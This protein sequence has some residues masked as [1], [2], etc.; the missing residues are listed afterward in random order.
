[1]LYEFE[2]YDPD[3]FQ[4][5]LGRLTRFFGKSSPAAPDYKG[6]ADAT[7]AGNLEAARAAAAANRVN[8]VTPYGTLNYTH[9][10][11]QG[12]D[13]GWTATQS[14]APEQQQQLA[15][16][17]KLTTG[18]L[19]TAGTGLGYVNDALSTG[20]K[21]D[22]SKLSQMPIAG[23]SVQD[24]IMS[25]LQPQIARNEDTL[26]TRLQNSGVF[27]G[28]E[29]WK[30]AM[31]DQSLSENDLY[32]NAALQGIN[33]GLQARQQGI[34]EQYGAQDRPLNIVNALRTGNQVQTPTFTNVPQ[35]Q[36]T[37][38]ADMLTAASQAGQFASGNAASQN[39][40]TASNVGSAA[41]VAA[42]YFF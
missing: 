20:G 30:N 7:A 42:A 1:M 19:G 41:M 17:N 18:L 22:E 5:K 31:R 38:G 10:T 39:A 23:Q 29:Q 33:T 16:T 26:R 37:P 3:G 36:A 15:E 13:S 35:Q 14:L 25:R 11:S 24:A 32:T 4:P 21:L 6:A 8:Q 9:D 27:E 12:P 2:P 40:S 28:S 34:Q